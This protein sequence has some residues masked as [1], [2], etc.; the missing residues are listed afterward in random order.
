M[1]V[2]Y[3][4]ATGTWIL[5]HDGLGG[6]AQYLS[7][8]GGDFTVLGTVTQISGD[9]NAGA[10]LVLMGEEGPLL[11]L[12]VSQA[13]T[14]VWDSYTVSVPTP[15]SAVS[16]H[17]KIEYVGDVATCFMSPDG[18]VWEQI[19]SGSLERP[20][21]AGI[22]LRYTDPQS[23]C[24]AQIARFRV[25]DGML[26]PEPVVVSMTAAAPA[27]QVSIGVQSYVEPVLHACIGAP[28]GDLELDVGKSVRWLMWL[29]DRQFI[30]DVNIGTPRYWVVNWA[31]T[32]S[33]SKH[34]TTSI[35]YFKR[36]TD[37]RKEQFAKASAAW[38]YDD[39]DWVIFCDA[40]EGLSV[41][42]RSEPDDWAMDPFRS[43]LYRE[44][45]ARHRRQP[46]L[47]LPPV[48][49]LR[50]AHRDRQCHLSDQ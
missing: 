29:T 40:S 45:R 13:G 21:D 3:N 49:R 23:F 1:T 5:R 28:F 7:L 37:F 2:S 14:Q 4:D 39:A 24:E 12:L 15:A 50:Q 18:M 44:I 41:D 46:R 43:Y 30:L 36:P 27:Q 6:E 20:V 10:G 8:P 31:E 19:A 33:G 25:F 32:F 26:S 22:V 16:I 34:D 11:Y 47:G 35:N 48:L 42:N 17:L 9:P 38:N